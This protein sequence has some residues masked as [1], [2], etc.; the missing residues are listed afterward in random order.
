MVVA[1]RQP[2]RHF[3][4][5]FDQGAGL[6]ELEGGGEMRSRVGGTMGAVADA[7]VAEEGVEE[8]SGGGAGGA[9]D[10]DGDGLEVEAEVL[11]FEAVLVALEGLGVGEVGGGDARR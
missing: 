7:H 4:A 5:A 6:G 2:Q 1:G 11:A 3:V 9:G 10:V 8:G